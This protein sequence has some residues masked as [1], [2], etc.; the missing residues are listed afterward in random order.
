MNVMVVDDEPLL[1]FHLQKMLQELWEDLDQVIPLGSGIEAVNMIHE[2]P[3][4]TVFLD[5]KMPGI[6][7]LE[8]AKLLRESGYVGH[9]VFVTAY[10]EHAVTA[11]EHEA[12]DYILKPIEEERL[13]QCI[14]R[15]IKRGQQEIRYELNAD[16][17][18]QLISPESSETAPLRWINATR[19]NQI[20][21]VQL[22]DIHC[23]IAEDKYTTVITAQGEYLIR[24]TIKQLTQELDSALFWRIHRAVIVQVAKIAMAERDDQGHYSVTLQDSDRILPVSRNNAHLF[25]QM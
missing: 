17:L 24:K 5:I 25:R 12:V 11:F 22:D 6:S 15:I 18:Q 9:I 16:Q 2:V 4:H 10:D 14:K 7:G 20:H 3:V 8:T 23:F 21:I 13:F 1:R 19:G